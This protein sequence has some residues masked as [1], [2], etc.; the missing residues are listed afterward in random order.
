MTGLFWAWDWVSSR[1]LWMDGGAGFPYLAASHSNAARYAALTRGVTRGCSLHSQWFVF[2]LSQ[3]LVVGLQSKPERRE[4][5]RQS[6]SG[7]HDGRVKHP[8]KQKELSGLTCQ[9][10]LCPQQLRCPAGGSP[11]QRACFHCAGTEADCFTR[12]PTHQVRTTI[13]R[14]SLI[15]W[16]QSVSLWFACYCFGSCQ[17]ITTSVQHMVPESAT[18]SKSDFVSF[19][20]NNSVQ[21]CIKVEQMNS[22]SISF[23]SSYSK[24][25]H[26][27]R[28]LK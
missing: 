23:Y 24:P 21:L 11:S 14:S 28:W 17:W 22:L 3:D 6:V 16:I 26:R 10:N 27:M 15:W 7:R 2:V 4:Q 20:E 25:I 5:A 18:T 1:K 8:W 13:S 9:G 12:T 19:W